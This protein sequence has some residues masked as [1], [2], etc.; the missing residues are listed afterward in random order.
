MVRHREPRTRPIRLP[1]A[2]R[3]W[4]LPAGVFWKVLVVIVLIW[5]L[6]RFGT[7]A[8]TAAHQPA[9]V[10]CPVQTTH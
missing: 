10:V 6:G 3:R 5:A 8:S 9:P 7:P 2:G 1:G 4:H